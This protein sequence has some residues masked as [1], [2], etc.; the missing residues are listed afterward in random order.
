MKNDTEK[1]GG[2]G[3]VLLPQDRSHAAWRSFFSKKI[4][5][6]LRGLGFWLPVGGQGGAG[7][8]PMQR[9]ARFLQ[10]GCFP[11]SVALVLGRGGGPGSAPMQRGARFLQKQSTLF[12]CRAS[13]ASI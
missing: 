10:E 1:M 12:Q 9:G 7:T 4:I 8:A 2:L 13:L 5:P 3:L 11:C 6:M